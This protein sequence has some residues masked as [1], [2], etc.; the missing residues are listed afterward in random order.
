MAISMASGPVCMYMYLCV[1]AGGVGGR[2]WLVGSL[3]VNHSAGHTLHRCRNFVTRLKAGLS[4]D[5]T[6]D[7][8]ATHGLPL[9]SVPVLFGVGSHKI[10]ERCAC[11]CCYWLCVVVLA[12]VVVVVVVAAGIN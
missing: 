9:A 2:L 6:G 7:I 8:N 10:T 3:I 4:I 1:C 11:S 12:G 5:M